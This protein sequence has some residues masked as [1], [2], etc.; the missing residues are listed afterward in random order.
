MCAKAEN[1]A[2]TVAVIAPQVIVPAG[3]VAVT[4]HATDV[5]ADMSVDMAIIALVDTWAGTVTGI[6]SSISVEPMS[7]ADHGAL[8]VAMTDS[9][10]GLSVP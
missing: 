8:G 10:F 3:A 6:L 9:E 7:A 4:G 2:V 1:I 5:R